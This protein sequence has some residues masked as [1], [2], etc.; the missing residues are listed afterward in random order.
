MIWV[1]LL[2]KCC[3]YTLLDG[4]SLQAYQSSASRCSIRRWNR[5][6]TGSRSLPFRLVDWQDWRHHLEKDFLHQHKS[7]QNNSATALD[8]K[9][10]SSWL[11][12]VLQEVH[13][14]CY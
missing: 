14:P 1:R 13:Q 3:T 9:R 7:C 11:H 10:T 12:R 8:S 2:C 5:S 4:Y 6:T